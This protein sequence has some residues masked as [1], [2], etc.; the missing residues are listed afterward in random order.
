MWKL[1][2]I[3]LAIGLIVLALARWTVEGLRWLTAGGSG[4]REPSGAPA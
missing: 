3:L 1:L 2:L 4:R